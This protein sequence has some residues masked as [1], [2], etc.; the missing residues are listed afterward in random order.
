MLIEMSDAET[1]SLSSWTTNAMDP[2][3]IFT[4]RTVAEAQLQELVAIVAVSEHSEALLDAAQ[5][6]QARAA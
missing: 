2:H 4:P 6:L 5:L 3:M 1:K